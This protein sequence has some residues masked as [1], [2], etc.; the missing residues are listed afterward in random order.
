[1]KRVEYEI[2]AIEEYCK[3]LPDILTVSE[4]AQVLRVSYS[5]AYRAVISGEIDATKV[6]GVWRVPKSALIVYLQQRHPFNTDYF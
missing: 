6:R 4:L 2:E 5:T 3:S 1:M